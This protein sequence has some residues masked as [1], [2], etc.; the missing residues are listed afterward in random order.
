MKLLFDHN[1]SPRLVPHLSEIYPGSIHVWT[2]GL[3]EASDLEIWETARAQG[4]YIVSKDSDFGDI[5]AI[6]GFPPKLVW[7]R[8]GNCATAVIADVLRR[9]RDLVQALEDDAGAGVLILY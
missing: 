3:A 6:R 1:L 5:A 7:L 9:D 8:V 4:F 2:L